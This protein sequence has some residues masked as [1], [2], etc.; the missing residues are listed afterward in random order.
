MNLHD[1]QTWICDFY[2]KRGWYE[3]NAFI[4]VNFIS[5]EVGEVARAVRAIEIGRDRPDEANE[6]QET[7]LAN[8]QEEIGDVLDSL[9]ILA[10]KYDLSLE[11]IMVSHI[12]KFQT[13]YPE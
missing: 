1:Y 13:R 5:E 9:F 6:T 2:K 4:R 3:Y 7:L 8:L 11:E 10:N 12:Q